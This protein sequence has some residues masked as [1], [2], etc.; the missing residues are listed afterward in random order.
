MAPTALPLRCDVVAG[1][2]PEAIKLAPVVIALRERPDEFTV[3]VVASGQ[4]GEICRSALAAFGLTANSA[5]DIGPIG[6]SL[7]DSTGDV[8]R[9]FGRHIADTC[10]DLILVQGDT[11]RLWPRRSPGFMHRFRSPI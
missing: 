9:A 1:T 2:R 6:R 5:L 11:P 7:A 8:V 4:Q 3:R 10:P